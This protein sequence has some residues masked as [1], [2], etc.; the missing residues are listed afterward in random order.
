M[1]NDVNVVQLTNHT[2]QKVNKIDSVKRYNLPDQIMLARL[3]AYSKFDTETQYT[4]FCDADSLFINKLFIPKDTLENI[5]LAPRQQDFIMNHNYPEYYE[6]FVGKRVNEV[7]RFLFGA[8]ITKENQQSFFK[9]LLDNCL[10]LPPRFH[11]WYGDQYALHQITQQG[12][13][14]YQELN[15]NI[16]LNVIRNPLTHKDLDELIKKKIQ[17]ITFKG[18]Q[19]KI[20]INNALDILRELRSNHLDNKTI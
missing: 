20:F 14:K 5:L 11:R 15:S 4:F 1:G 6:E 9:S 10:K 13:I 17:M 8:I 7:M 18:P 12:F 16:Y 19:S 2:T 3:K